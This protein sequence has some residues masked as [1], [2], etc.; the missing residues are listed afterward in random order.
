[1]DEVRVTVYPGKVFFDDK[2]STGCNRAMKAIG[3]LAV[4]GIRIVGEG[5]G[6][7]TRGDGSFRR[8]EQSCATEQCGCYEVFERHER[9][10]GWWR[11]G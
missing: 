3:V 9:S 8:G 6:S 1:V 2:G 4:I 10:P 5:N 7:G 11:E